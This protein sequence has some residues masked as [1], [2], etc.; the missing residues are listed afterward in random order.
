[1]TFDFS[2]MS[3]SIDLIQ[4]TITSLTEGG[5]TSIVPTDGASLIDNWL[6]LLDHS[7]ATQQVRTSLEELKSQLDS[8][9]PDATTVRTILLDLSE[10]LSVQASNAEHDLRAPL[11]DLANA[12]QGFAT[13]L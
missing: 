12:I 10:Q 4:S 1:V 2:R 3:Q 5:V 7:P 6:D 9:Y 11:R 8:G 13:S